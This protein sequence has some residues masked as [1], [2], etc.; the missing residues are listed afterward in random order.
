MLL[1]CVGLPNLFVHPFIILFQTTKPIKKKKFNYVRTDRKQYRKHI[2][3]RQLTVTKFSSI[4]LFVRLPPRWQPGPALNCVRLSLHC[5]EL[6][7]L[8]PWLH[9]VPQYC[10]LGFGK[11]FS[12]LLRQETTKTMPSNKGNSRSSL[13]ALAYCAHSSHNKLWQGRHY[14]DCEAQM[15]ASSKLRTWPRCL[16]LEPPATGSRQI[17]VTIRISCI[18]CYIRIFTRSLYIYVCIL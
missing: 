4:P 15:G 3:D 12:G 6:L 13:C 17:A 8:C 18:G 14:L 7:Y 2:V 5:L 1:L 10:T 16:P 9:T 11:I